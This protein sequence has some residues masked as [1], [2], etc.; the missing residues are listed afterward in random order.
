MVLVHAMRRG[1]SRLCGWSAAAA[2]PADNL[3]DIDQRP[4]SPV[5]DNLLDIENSVENSVDYV[6]V[7]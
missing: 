7:C 4:L 2:Q 5:A 3:I 6:D 1:T